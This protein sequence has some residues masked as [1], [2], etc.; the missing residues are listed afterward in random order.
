MGTRI[1]GV[2]VVY[3]FYPSKYTIFREYRGFTPFILVDTLY[4]GSTGGFTPFILVGI[5]EVNGGSL[6]LS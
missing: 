4:A 5:H 2:K 1:P 6:L 3:S